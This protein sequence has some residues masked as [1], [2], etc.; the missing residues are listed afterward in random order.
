MSDLKLFRVVSSKAEELKGSAMELEKKL[1]NLIEANMETF[2]GVK[3]L[4][5]E[6]STGHKHTQRWMG[7]RWCGYPTLKPADRS[8]RK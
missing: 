3:F 4:A 1:Q 7:R 5:T 6:Y 8:F 2:F